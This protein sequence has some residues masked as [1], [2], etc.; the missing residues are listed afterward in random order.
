MNLEV[1]LA[2]YIDSECEYIESVEIG[3]E[4]QK[5][6]S[7]LSMYVTEEGEELLDVCKA[8]Y[9]MP[10]EILEQNP[11]LAFPTQEGEQVIYFRRLG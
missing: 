6:T 2:K 11:N 4:R 10:D 8:L 9:A 5:N 1:A 3:A 7:A